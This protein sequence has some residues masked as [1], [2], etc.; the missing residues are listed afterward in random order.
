MRERRRRRPAEHAPDAPALNAAAIA[1]FAIMVTTAPQERSRPPL[2]T[3]T[4][5]M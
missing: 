5:I 3:A 2:T 1:A 4:A